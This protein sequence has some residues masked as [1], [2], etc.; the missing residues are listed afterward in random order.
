MAL[1][2]SWLLCLF[3]FLLLSQQCLQLAYA[4][5]AAGDDDAG[6][7]EDDEAPQAAAEPAA[8]ENSEQ[9]VLVLTQSNFDKVSYQS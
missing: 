1:S 8:V 3:G 6:E 9:N 5:E 2:K 7:Y 4:D